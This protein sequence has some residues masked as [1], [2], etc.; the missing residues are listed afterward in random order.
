MRNNF[1]EQT[2]PAKPASD[3][4]L[5][6]TRD[7]TGIYPK[8]RGRSDLLKKVASVSVIVIC[9]FFLGKA[10]YRNLG[11][12]TTYQWDLKPL[13]LLFSFLF[14]IINLTVSAFAWKKV[15]FLF[16]IRLPL[17]Q[18][19]KITFVSG[20]GRYLPGKVWSYLS[21]IYL[22]QKAEIPKSVTIFSVLLLF[23]ISSLV[24]M[25][26]FICS[27]FLWDRF[28]PTLISVSLLIFS[29]FLLIILSPRVLNRILRIST[30]ISN[31]FKRGL[32]PGELVIRGGMAHI[33]EIILI[34][35]ANWMIFGTA[36]YFLANSF[37]R[38]DFHQTV[39][40][41]GIFAI[42][43]ISGIVSFFVPAGLGVREGVLSYLLS[44]FVPISTAI[45]ISLLI[46][47]WTTLG[48][49]AC[50]F[51]ALKIKK[52]KLF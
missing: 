25:L 51:V 5:L 38:F 14:L 9:F 35:I 39:I 44:F 49:L 48:E 36:I 10:L 8:L 42:S 45:V 47:V 7:K 21:Q 52:P 20:L 46:R 37:Y 41:C 1:Q 31:K 28:S 33:G 40:L 24:G 32:I 16:G 26:V 12:I 27:L 23:G 13:Y 18:S 29:A 11:E 34:F 50:F 6:A 15:L 2:L 22:S 19:F 43:V 17:D 3:D 4:S 30:F